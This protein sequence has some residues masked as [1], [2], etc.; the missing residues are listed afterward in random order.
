M[1]RG[2]AWVYAMT[3]EKKAMRGCKLRPMKNQ[4]CV[5]ESCDQSKI[6]IGCGSYGSFKTI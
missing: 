4:Q 2:I 5:G 3:N 6:S 1:K